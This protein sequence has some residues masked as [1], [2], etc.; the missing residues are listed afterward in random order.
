MRRIQ[1]DKETFLPVAQRLYARG[2]RLLKSSHIAETFQVDG[3]WY[4]RR[5]RIQDHMQDG[6]ETDV[7]VEKIE[8]DVE[9]PRSRFSRAALRR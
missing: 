5:L 8:F 3:R 7:I 2:G 6:E 4:P 1:V 9:I